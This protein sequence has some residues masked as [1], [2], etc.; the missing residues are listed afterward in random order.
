MKTP[1]DKI[2]EVAIKQ[3]RDPL[4]PIDKCNHCNNNVIIINNKEIY[5]N[6]YGEWPWIYYCDNC[7][8]Y[9][10]I[11]S[12]TNIPLGTLAD[13]Q[14]RKA[15]Q[16]CKKPFVDLYKTKKMTKNRAYRLLSIKLN[17]PFSKCHFGMFD[18]NMCEKALSA[19][20]IIEKELLTDFS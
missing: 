2:D 12:Y 3:I 13:E 1:F 7:G 18:I 15:R 10:G 8:A 11:H 16:V 17:I 6:S 4:P 14:T 19:I 5:G 9:V 20:K